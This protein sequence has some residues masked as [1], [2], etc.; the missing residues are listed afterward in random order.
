M[1]LRRRVSTGCRFGSKSFEGVCDIVLGLI[2]G[3]WARGSP[4][5]GPRDPWAPRI[6]F[7]LSFPFPFASDFRVLFPFPFAFPLPF[8]IAFPFAFPLPLPFPLPFPFPFLFFFLF[9]FLFL[10][11]LCFLCF[12]S[13]PANPRSSGSS[14]SS[15]S[16]GSGP[17]SGIP[18]FLL[19]CLLLSFTILLLAFFCPP[20]RWE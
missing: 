12:S 11:L 20:P 13:F 1:Q 18:D 8:P 2:A 15:E 19:F 7:L 17:P 5:R 14:G 9:L 6:P 16:P 10:I 4:G 3:R